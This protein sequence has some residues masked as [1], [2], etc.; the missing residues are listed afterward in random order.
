MTTLFPFLYSDEINVRKK[1]DEDKMSQFFILPILI[2]L[3]RATCICW[4]RC[5][6]LRSE[7]PP[8]SCPL[9]TIGKNVFR[10]PPEK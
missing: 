9:T 10:S 3:L 4:M 5:S 1:Y 7:V 2:P 8:D 6:R